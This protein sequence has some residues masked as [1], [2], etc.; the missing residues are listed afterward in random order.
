MES[1]EVVPTV[2][3]QEIVDVVHADNVAANQELLEQVDVL[4]KAQE[5]ETGMSVVTMSDAQYDQLVSMLQY[6]NTFGVMGCIS[7]M[8]VCGAVVA[9]LVVRGWR[10]E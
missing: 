5:A 9:G 4:L 6:Q 7:T 2:T 3:A 8:C 1:N 10:H